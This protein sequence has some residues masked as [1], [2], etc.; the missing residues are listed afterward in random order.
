MSEEPRFFSTFR[1][2]IAHHVQSACQH[3]YETMAAHAK[4]QSL[5]SRWTGA[6]AV[7]RKAINHQYVLGISI[8]LYV[9]RKRSEVVILSAVEGGPASQLAHMIDSHGL[10]AECI[11]AL[12]IDRWRG[13]RHR[14]RWGSLLARAV[15]FLMYPPRAIMSA[16]GRAACIPTT[17]PFFL[18]GLLIATRRFHGSRIITL[19]YDVYP[20]AFGDTRVPRW[21]RTVLHR[22]NDYWMHRSD[23]VVFISEG[24]AHEMRRRH[25]APARGEVIPTG[26]D[27]SVFASRVPNT[28]GDSPVVIS[29]IGNAGLVHDVDTVTELFTRLEP[30]AGACHVRVAVSGARAGTLIQAARRFP[31]GVASGPLGH[32]AWIAAM[33]E[34]DIALVTLDSNAAHASMPSKFY[35]A[36]GAGCAVLAITPTGSELARATRRLD[37]G[38]E[39]SPGDVRA[40]TAEIRSLVK[41]RDRLRDIQA[42]ARETALREFSHERLSTRWLDVIGHAAS[43]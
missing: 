27:P 31:G 22:L 43:R 6:T 41:D 26:T 40:A 9:M 2:A 28:D 11:S 25:G 37:V 3:L 33:E 19:V 29:Y 21:L 12:T 30:D 34:T 14:G 7:H 15:V 38:V 4:S 8:G 18:P 36:L 32:H 35:S 10:P 23:T 24:M 5:P 20:D 42:R 13:L 17:N 39:V 1:R 16:R